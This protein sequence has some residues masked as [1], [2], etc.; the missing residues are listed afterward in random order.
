MSAAA[1][2][3][4]PLVARILAVLSVVPDPEIP[5][6]TLADLGILRGVEK[7]PAGDWQAIL[8]PTYSGCPATKE[9]QDSVRAALDEHGL[10][11]VGIRSRLSPAWT[12]DWITEEGREKLR[13]DGIAPPERGANEARLREP[14][15]PACPRCA[16]TDSEEISRFGSTPCKSMW[17]CRACREPFEHFKCH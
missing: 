2:A 7:N 10:H 17:R 4:D 3:A 8:T 14:V 15:P 1:R 16:S 11:K 12:T 13:A 5:A 9:I 6:V